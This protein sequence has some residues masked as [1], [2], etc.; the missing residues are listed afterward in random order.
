MP[1]IDIVIF[2]SAIASLLLFF[3]FCLI[4]SL[5][6]TQ[7]FVFL[8]LVISSFKNGISYTSFFKASK[9]S[10]F[11][12]SINLSLLINNFLYAKSAPVGFQTPASMTMASMI[13]THNDIYYFLSVILTIVTWIL[14]VAIYKHTKY[15]SPFS[16][17]KLMWWED[18]KEA[19][20]IFD[21]C[22]SLEILWT[23]IPTF[24]L[25]FIGYPNISLLYALDQIPQTW[26]NIKVTGH[27]WYWTYEYA[28][29]RSKD[30][31]ST[32]LAYDSTLVNDFDLLSV[33]KEDEI[34]T[35]PDWFEEEYLNEPELDFKYVTVD[36]PLIIPAHVDIQAIVTSA[37]V[38]HS[39]AIPALGVKV[40]ACP[41]RLNRITFKADID[42]RI[43]Q[44][45]F[46][47]KILKY[48][49]TMPNPFF[50]GYIG[51]CSELCGVGHGFMPIVVHAIHPEDMIPFI[52]YMFKV[53]GY[54]PDHYATSSTR[55]KA[56][57][58]IKSVLD[59]RSINYE[60][61]SNPLDE[62]GLYGGKPAIFRQ[63]MY[64]TLINGL[65]GN[66]FSTKTPY[67]TSDIFLDM[68]MKVGV[69]NRLFWISKY[70]KNMNTFLVDRKV[71][72]DSCYEGHEKL[73]LSD[74]YKDI[75][76]DK[77]ASKLQAHL[78]SE[79]RADID[80]AMYSK[81]IELYNKYM[82]DA[83]SL[84]FSSNK[85]FAKALQFLTSQINTV[86]DFNAMIKL[87][88]PL[89]D[90]AFKCSF[91]KFYTSV[92]EES[93]NESKPYIIKDPYVINKLHQLYVDCVFNNDPDFN[94][95]KAFKDI[96]EECEEDASIPSAKTNYVLFSILRGIYTHE[97]T[98]NWWKAHNNNPT[99]EEYM[100][101]INDKKTIDEIN[102][103]WMA[104]FLSKELKSLIL[105][106]SDK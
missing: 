88:G 19:A 73:D 105:N 45:A 34:R 23:I 30:S 25:L 93:D 52:A 12:F 66:G 14:A 100:D 96:I 77:L 43:Y 68:D 75:D 90:P 62:V 35:L 81:V 7:Y 17:P 5:F 37:D 2:I 61:V 87:K 74:Y 10:G 9:R 4:C 82:Y 89:S 42:S 72:P 13:C 58:N 26:F 56:Y 94:Y 1:Q 40:D 50:V 78:C 71:F 18:K 33:L 15:I 39:W 70:W 83:D 53:M 49:A 103:F 38:L 8:K 47:S 99:F 76:M 20:E 67:P 91:E 92:S 6:S 102:E 46:K 31:S 29:L 36:N 64:S 44:I 57:S 24:I 101:F 22:T 97:L 60:G 21:S 80:D 3:Y 104:C 79:I 98:L 27:Q 55:I 54:S 65:M 106:S 28:F 85:A 69:L 11:F 48:L 59:I 95:I 51:Q 41:G 16:E 86:D 84:P 63:Y 32:R